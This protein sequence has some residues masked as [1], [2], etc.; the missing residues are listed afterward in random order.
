MS[1]CRLLYTYIPLQVSTMYHD[2]S[3]GNA[4]NVALVKIMLLEEEEV[5]VK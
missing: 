2:S 4:V 3:I 5:S 1:A